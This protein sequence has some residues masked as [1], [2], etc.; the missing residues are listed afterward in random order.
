[1]SRCYL[2]DPGPS[3]KACSSCSAQWFIDL[4]SIPGQLH[5]PPSPSSTPLRSF[6]P[7]T[8]SF[9]NPCFLFFF[10]FSCPPLL[11]WFRLF[12]LIPFLFLFFY[13]SPS[14]SSQVLF[15]L[16]AFL[17]SPSF[18]PNPSSF[19]FLS[20]HLLF[21][22]RPLTFFPFVPYF[23]FLFLSSIIGANYFALLL[24][25]DDSYLAITSASILPTRTT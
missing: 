20:S 3:P 11:S 12:V 21:P 16:F 13:S 22:S 8:L 19:F 4:T 5:P 2:A 1:M 15:G 17:S 23:F 18:S 9:L 6:S 10:R 14:F 25:T 7:A 24:F